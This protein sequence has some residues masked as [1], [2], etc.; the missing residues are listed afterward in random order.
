MNNIIE[1]IL[2]LADSGIHIYLQDGKLNV[3]AQDSAQLDKL[4]PRIR[5]HK[6]ELIDYLS[7]HSQNDSKTMSE[8][9]YY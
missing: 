3:N 7:N 4:M 5:M 9:S 2:E 1:L 6:Q 8:S